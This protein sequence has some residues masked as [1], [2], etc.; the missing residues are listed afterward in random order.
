MF[1]FPHICHRNNNL[2]HSLVTTNVSLEPEKLHLQFDCDFLVVV[3]D[4]MRLRQQAL[5][6]LFSTFDLNVTMFGTI[7][8][9][10]DMSAT[11]S[12]FGTIS[13]F[14]VVH[15]SEHNNEDINQLVAT[16]R[17]TGT[18]EPNSRHVVLVSS[19]T[20]AIRHIADVYIVTL[21][22]TLSKMHQALV[23]I[24]SD[25]LNVKPTCSSR[26]TP[27]VDRSAWILVVDDVP[28]NQR[29][30]FL[31]LQQRGFTNVRFA[32][33]GQEAIDE[34]QR[35]SFVYDFI[36][37]DVMMPVVDGLEA[38]RRIRRDPRCSHSYYWNHWQL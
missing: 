4:T 31:K 26:S 23:A 3:I 19:L 35:T 1:T 20:S 14:I 25:S 16:L 27:H 11:I 2:D 22:V 38:T 33:N 21:P 32:N 28:L 29:L 8:Q 36:L 7:Q 15:L 12:N 34:V 17:T 6:Q 5:Y 10:I 18:N 37:M 13:L 24:M 9:F 30:I